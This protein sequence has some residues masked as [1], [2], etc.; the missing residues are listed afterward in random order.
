VADLRAFS[1]NGDG[2]KDKLTLSDSV[3]GSDRVLDWKLGIYP[4][5]ETGQRV[6]QVKAVKSWA[7]TAPIPATFSWSGER[8]EGTKAADGRYVALL[9][10]R[11]PNR[12]SIEA[13][14]L[15]LVLDTVAPSISASAA[16]LLFSPNEESSLKTTTITQK[17]VP[18]D[19]WEGR[20]VDSGGQVVRNWSWHDQVETIVWDGSDDAG[21]KVRDGSYRYEVSSTDAAGNVGK[22]V[23]PAIGVDARRPQVA[24]TAS[25]TG[26]S[27]NK[28]GIQD[29]L[30][31]S[32][33]V[34]LKDGISAWKLAILD[35]QGAEKLVK[36]G[37]GTDL[38]T[39]FEWDGKNASGA[40]VEGTYKARLA[41]S[42][43][44][45][46]N[47]VATS[48]SFV[49][50]LTAPVATVKADR[51]AFN[52][53]GDDR[54]NRVTFTQ[55]GSE[56]D[57]WTGEI[58]AANG[59]VLR[60]WTW[61]PIPEAN[62]RWDGTDDAGAAVP[63]GDYRYRLRATD[64]GGN[65]FVSAPLPVALDTEKKTARLVADLRAFSPNG[66]GQKDTVNLTDTVQGNLRAASWKLGLY[67]APEA[68][69]QLDRSKSL[70]TWTGTG[71][72][73]A[74]FVWAGIRDDGTKAPDGRHIALLELRWPNGDV[75]EA[76]TLPI[77]LDTT[78]PSIA[79]S[80]APLLFSPNE[81]SLLRTTT[82]S[83]KA[84]PGDDWE[85]RLLDS[86]GAV[87]RSWSWKGQ[88]A[89]I[90]WNAT[91]T[92]GNLVKDGSYRYEVS[93]TDAAGNATKAIVPAIVVDARAVQ[94]FVTASATG[95]SPN[96]D[97]V[98]DD[99]NFS[100]I[101]NLREGIA[102]WR[103][104]LVDAS[105]AEAAS[106]SG[107]GADMPARLTWNGKNSAGGIV[108]G[109]YTG[110]FRVDYAKGD[111]VEAK[112]G[113]L[114]VDVT[115]PVVELALSPPYFSPDNDGV[116]DEL[117][118]S[119]A[120]KDAS[121]LAGWKLEIDEASIEET[122]GAA[123]KE[124]LFASWSGTGIPASLITWDGK[125]T[126]GELVE[127][128]TD[129]P[130]YLDVADIYGNKTRVKGIV[131]VDV[132]VIREGDRL[133]I[134]VPSIVFRAN[135][136]DFVGLDPDTVAKNQKVIGRIAEILNKFKDYRIAIEGHANSIGK[137]Y[138]YTAAKI[139]DEEQKELV[140]L[141]TN[142]ADLV[143]KMLVTAGVDARRLTVL[144]RGSSE[145]VV[146]FKDAVNRWKNRRVE[147]ILIKTASP[148]A[149]SGG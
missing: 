73:P 51:V 8:D 14:T 78:P 144:G 33:D 46:N 63:D 64:R 61:K 142:R 108:E 67:A 11:Y 10:A 90:V 65:A 143:R 127:S 66:D 84:V 34:T 113:T 91:D 4:A 15:S 20:L 92:A 29:S 81:Q 129:Y 45:G 42:Y 112:T 35:A 105:G 58:L 41:V 5:T 86:S 31:L 96:G 40:I 124:R 100:L 9:E 1:P 137:I 125:S 85:G 12:D 97:G 79:L 69:Q 109:N 16:P 111:R 140:P 38:P 7:G 114:A 60:T 6:D 93:S 48:P 47:P 116:D 71:A 72:P 138:G 37:T 135:F 82:I 110:I 50:D 128:A 54:Q 55:T 115:G 149:G 39:K 132:L 28:D 121:E 89:D 75:A 95:L 146:D 131:A 62:L 27:P 120:V 53:A 147:F 103:F 136:A 133:K 56:E 44:N 22:A 32:I 68:G 94:V 49:L 74:S 126:K 23:I 57:R 87:I 145:P 101:V 26:L 30:V 139:T 19:D 130:L 118:M 122:P 59:K 134:K 99:I 117:S 13:Q 2:V 17:A 107:A 119:L 76:Q 98:M 25:A 83:Q 77:V 106:F 3:T 18:G 141:S 80:A 36:T 88:V 123:P 24:V 148:A 104:S 43:L 21:N 102:S 52:P 70:K